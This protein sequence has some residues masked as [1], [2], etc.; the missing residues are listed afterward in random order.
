MSRT[1]SLA[2]AVLL[3]AL[4]GDLPAQARGD[5]PEEC[6]RWRREE[7]SP[8]PGEAEVRCRFDIAGPGRFGLLSYVDVPVYQPATPMPGTHVVGVP[9]HA[10]PYPGESYEAWEWRVL[11]TEY[12]PEARRVR[13]GLELLDPVVAARILKLE[14]RLRRE[15]I[16]FRRRETWRLPERQAWLFQQGRS[17]PGP[18]ATS[19][20]TSWHSQVDEHGH[21]AG[22]AA[23]YSVPA[24]QMERFHEIAWRAGLQSFGHDSN[25]PGHVFLPEQALPHGEITLLRVLPRVPEVTLATGLPVDR[26]LPPGGRDALRAAALE[27]ASQP[28]LPH[29]RPSLAGRRPAARVVT[30]VSEGAAAPEGLSAPARSAAAGGGAPGAPRRSAAPSAGGSVRNTGG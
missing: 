24:A 12:G 15:G 30:R 18:L 23:D 7:P 2:T 16:A 9:G 25:D 27:F 1:R 29:V 6:A 17:R 13:T 28:F 20:L 19:T 5:A 4:A 22:R 10:G 21:A 3:L 8:L 14:G 26:G 11:R